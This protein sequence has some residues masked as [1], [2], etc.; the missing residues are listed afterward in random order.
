MESAVYTNL[1]FKEFFK[2]TQWSFGLLFRISKSMTLLN[3]IFNILDK[4]SPIF[5]AIVFAKALDKAIQLISVP[6]TTLKDLLPYLFFMILFLLLN[7]LFSY[8]KTITG[9]YAYHKAEYVLTRE[10]Y[11]KLKEL[12]V[13]RLEEPEINNQIARVKDTLGTINSHIDNV[14]LLISNFINILT[15]ALIVFNI[16]P[17]LII[18]IIPIASLYM[19]FDSKYRKK[20]YNYIFNSTE[21]VRRANQYS[22]DLTNSKKLEEITINNAFKFFDERYVKFWKKY[23]DRLIAIV[24]KRVSGLYTNQFA[25][26]MITAIGYILSFKNVLLGVITIG[27]AT[28]AIKSLQLMQDSITDTIL[29]FNK[30]YEYSVKLKDAYNLFNTES[31]IHKGTIKLKNLTSGPS[32]KIKDLKFRYP[33]SSK[34]IYDG[35]N[36]EID[37]GEKIAIVGHNGAGKTTLVKLISRF[38]EPNAGK[39]LVNGQDL[40]NISL[41]S[42]YQ[43]EG[44][45]PDYLVACVGGGSNAIG[46]FAPFVD[47]QNVKMLGIEP[48]G[49]GDKPGENAA[50]LTYGKPGELHGFKSYVLYDDQD[51]NVISHTHSIAA[52]LDYPG[53]GPEH[54]FLKDSGRAEYTTASDQEALD[55]FHLL[56]EKEG[57]IPA[58]ES[59]H[60][61]AGGMKIAAELDQDQIVIINLSGR[62]D[63]DVGQIKELHENG[64]L[65]YL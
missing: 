21:S 27:N 46:L 36:L 63:K 59:A 12:G 35:F 37:A 32:I 2:L 4:L 60:A 34:N 30:S 9:N 55:A 8:L 54:S 41:D 22:D 29:I 20:L 65:N 10:L 38:Y 49:K 39:I 51:E 52:G 15:S 47:D 31:R 14:I 45:L 23:T 33:D 16:I 18:P 11:F 58:L 13:Q 1:S 26:D 64:K 19:I 17:W 25:Y 24:F 50:P 53:V 43:K 44:K 56:S 48:G 57:I 61:I 5:N 42:Y 28:L 6:G 7:T 3:V 40:E 62:G